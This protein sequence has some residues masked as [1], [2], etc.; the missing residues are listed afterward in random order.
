M[1]KI[2]RFILSGAHY[3]PDDDSID[4]ITEDFTTREAAAQRAV[5]IF[6]DTFQDKADEFTVEGC[7]FGNDFCNDGSD[8]WVKLDIVRIEIPVPINGDF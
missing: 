6:Q 5:E 8:E 1:S 4:I 7:Q 3:H 2:E